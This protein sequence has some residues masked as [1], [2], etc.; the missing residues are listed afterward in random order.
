MRSKQGMKRLKYASAEL[1][2]TVFGEPQTA[3]RRRSLRCKTPQDMGGETSLTVTKIARLIV[4][5]FVCGFRY[6]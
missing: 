5:K 6:T 1:I 4:T 3:F 2:G